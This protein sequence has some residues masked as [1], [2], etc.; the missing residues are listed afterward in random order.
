MVQLPE[1]GFPPNL[2]GARLLILDATGNVHSIFKEGPST[3]TGAYWCDAAKEQ[4]P[5][6]QGGEILRAGLTERQDKGA[7]YP[8]AVGGMQAMHREHYIGVEEGQNGGWEEAFCEGEGRGGGA[9][10]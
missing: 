1:F 2:C 3:S 9:E 4:G 5:G 6:K 10:R 8:R 7:A